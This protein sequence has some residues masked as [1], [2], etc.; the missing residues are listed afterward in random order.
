MQNENQ[1]LYSLEDIIVWVWGSDDHLRFIKEIPINGVL[2]VNRG[3]G[4]Y[5]VHI[6]ILD[7]FWKGLSTSCM[8]FLTF[9]CVEC[10]I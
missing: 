2:F 6:Y 7:V 5:A 9:S 8:A 3:S 1:G 4:K 10:N